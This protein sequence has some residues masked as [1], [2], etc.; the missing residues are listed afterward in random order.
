MIHPHATARLVGTLWVAAATFAAPELHAQDVPPPAG[1]DASPAERLRSGEVH[2]I[3]RT[4]A[5]DLHLAVDTLRAPVTAGN[6]LRYVD[7]SLYTGGTFYRAVRLDNQPDDDVRIEVVQG[8]MDRSRRE[9]ALDPIPLES[10]DATGLRHL[11]GTLSMARSGPNSARAEF[12]I[13]IGDQ[14]SLD[15]GGARNPDGLGFAAFGRVLDGMDVVR[16][17][18]RGET[19][20]QYLVTRVGIRFVERVGTR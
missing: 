1:P 4:D 18:Q 3:M 14:P 10:T 12:F 11:D 7:R 5:G 6:F 16:E 19:D 9:E 8:G 15:A 20:G 17:I 13:T 2:L